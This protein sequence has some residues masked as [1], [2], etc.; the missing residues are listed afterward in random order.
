MLCFHALA[1]ETRLKLFRFLV[2]Q[3]PDGMPA[4]EIAKAL[5]CPP[6]T[7]SFHLKALQEAALILVHRK[8]RSLIY[9]PNLVQANALTSFLFENCCGGNPCPEDGVSREKM[10]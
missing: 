9:V 7:L 3:G 5:E 8:G 2:Q 1:Q 4:G 10:P 6:S